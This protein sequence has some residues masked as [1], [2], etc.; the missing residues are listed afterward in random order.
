MSSS[1]C[2]QKVSGARE[3]NNFR[4]LPGQVGGGSTEKSAL[5][6]RLKDDL[7]HH[8]KNSNGHQPWGR[9]V[10]TGNSTLPLTESRVST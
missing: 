9:K 10:L 7:T 1:K 5:R 8:I 6:I 3:G 4:V 2:G